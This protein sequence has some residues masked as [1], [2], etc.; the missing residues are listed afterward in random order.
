MIKK[1]NQYN[2]S[3]RDQMKPKVLTGVIKKVYNAREQLFKIGFTPTKIKYSNGIYS[4]HID[5]SSFYDG[6]IDVELNYY[7]MKEMVKHWDESFLKEYNKNGWGGFIF[8]TSNKTRKSHED[9]IETENNTWEEALR[10]ILDVMYP[11]IDKK[12]REVKNYDGDI[13]DIED[14]LKTLK[15]VK[16]LKNK[17]H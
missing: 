11:N 12:I 13:E 15:K 6:D 1:F 3:I 17:I 4:F 7:D 16:V 9:K 10:V 8:Y 14:E 2:E 5:N